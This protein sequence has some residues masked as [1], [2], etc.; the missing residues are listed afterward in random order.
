MNADQ[1]TKL[2]DAAKLL[3]HAKADIEAVRD[4]VVEEHRA[5][6]WREH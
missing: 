3:R 5:S 1:M 2:T 6:A 4:A